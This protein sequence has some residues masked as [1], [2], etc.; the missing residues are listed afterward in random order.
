MD[1][2]QRTAEQT[3]DALEAVGDRPGGDGQGACSCSDVLA[4]REP[5]LQRLDQCGAAAWR[6]VDHAELET[7]GHLE[8]AVVGEERPFELYRARIDKDLGLPKTPVHRQ[9]AQRPRHGRAVLDAP[10][11]SGPGRPPPE[12]VSPRLGV[13]N[14]NS[15]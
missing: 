13:G 9:S 2:L 11:N 6:R 10:T 15:P 14:C 4:I 1:A 7:N 12:D 5:R 3:L 8:Q